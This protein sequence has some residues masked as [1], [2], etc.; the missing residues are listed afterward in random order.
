MCAKRIPGIDEANWA[1]AKLT[2]PPVEDLRRW[3]DE[4]LQTVVDS[5][6]KYHEEQ[7]RDDQAHRGRLSSRRN[8]LEEAIGFY[9]EAVKDLHQRARAR[10][11]R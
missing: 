11:S 2:E 6:V 3:R 10:Q 9:V 1:N 8:S 7:G 5:A 4:A